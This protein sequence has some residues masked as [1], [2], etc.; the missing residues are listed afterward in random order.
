MSIDIPQSIR[1]IFALQEIPEWLKEIF[2]LKGYSTLGDLP[3]NLGSVSRAEAKAINHYL[4]VFIT[5]KASAMTRVNSICFPDSNLTLNYDVARELNLSVR[6]YNCIVAFLDNCG[7]SV[8]LCEV[9]LRD[10][11]Q[12]Y[13]MGAKSILEFLSKIEEFDGSAGRLELTNSPRLE[14]ENENLNKDIE[15][16][17]SQIQQCSGIDHIIRGDPRFPELNTNFPDKSYQAGSS[18]EEL[19]QFSEGDYHNWPMPDR[20]RLL[21]L[22]KSTREKIVNLDEQFLEGQLK[23]FIGVFY[24]RIKETNLNAILSRFGVNREGILTLEECGALAG[25]TRE[26][27]RQLEA[28]VLKGTKSI[29]GFSPIYMPKLQL[30]IDIIQESLGTTV[31]LIQERFI[32]KGISKIGLSVSSVLLFSKLL[33]FP[34]NNLSVVKLKDGKEIVIGDSIDVRHI[35]TQLGKHYSRNGI[36]DLRSVFETVSEKSKN[37][38]YFEVLN[39]VKNSSRWKAIDAEHN[40]WIPVNDGEINRNRLE[41]ILN[42]I[43][44]VCNSVD[45]EE[46]YSG[47]QR[48]A[49]FRNSSRGKDAYVIVPPSISAIKA[50]IK[51]S[52]KYDVTTQVVTSLEHLDYRR[53]LSEVEIGIVESLR[54]SSSG[55][56]SRKELLRSCI[57]RGLNEMSVS[58][59]MTYSPVVMHVGVDAHALVGAKTNSGDLSAHLISHSERTKAKTKR[60]LLCDWSNGQIRFVVRCPEFTSNMVVGCPSS[61]KKFLLERKFNGVNKS[62]GEI[63]GTIGISDD[64]A[65]Y[66]MGPFCRQESTVL[67][68][69]IVME[70]GLLNG[71][72]TLSTATYEEYLEMLE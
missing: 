42:K 35:T 56:M 26:R 55:L 4:Q 5:R 53:E 45:L 50:F 15:K 7:G 8:P 54:S 69:I 14:I 3:S 9:T 24:R 1:S 12:I 51:Q 49:A 39:V 41:N 43:L 58:M 72:A 13:A 52:K 16:Y 60:L 57:E 23:Y 6:T 27:I 61:M 70:F 67:G 46:I 11:T 65:I 59:Y 40:W 19:L 29:P 20:K 18:L 64:G 37:M 25:L 48:L 17:V 38:S 30:A 10:L 44:S 36:A 63:F 32:S 22:A 34:E 28:K 21:A 62:T 47:Y 68:D 66:G 33:R 31:E 2:G 71:T